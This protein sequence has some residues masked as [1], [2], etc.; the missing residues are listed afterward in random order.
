MSYAIIPIMAG[1]EIVLGSFE[2]SSWY[3]RGAEE[4]YSW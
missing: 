2:T 1:V 3:E 4:R